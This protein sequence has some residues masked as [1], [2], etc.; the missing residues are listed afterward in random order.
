MNSADWDSSLGGCS[1]LGSGDCTIGLGGIKEPSKGGQFSV[2]S[3]TEDRL[4]R[5]LYYKDWRVIPADPELRENFKGGSSYP[6]YS[7]SGEHEDVSRLK[8]ALLVGRDEKRCSG[9][10]KQVFD[11][12]SGQSTKSDASRCITTTTSP[13]MEVGR[14]FD[15]IV[16]FLR[17]AAENNAI[18]VIVDRSTKNAHFILIKNTD[19]LE[20]LDRI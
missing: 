8:A 1:G 3:N 15:F 18:W 17:T 2:R 9:V 16:G 5:A 11:V 4:R 14:C 20:S 12:Y 7:S 10:L 19:S 6:L 13:R